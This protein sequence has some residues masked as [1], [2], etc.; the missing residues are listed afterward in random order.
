MKKFLLNSLWIILAIISFGA[1]II[2]SFFTT[3]HDIVGYI[4]M[5]AAALIILYAFLIKKKF[6][7]ILITLTALICVG[8]V[9]FGVAEAPIIAGSKTDENP[10]AAY[11]IV[12]GAGVN[13]YNPSVTLNNRLTA[14]L[15]YLKSYPESKAVV[16]GGQGPGE[17]VTEAKAM[18]DWLIQNGIS[19]DRIIQEDKSTSTIE[20]L[21]F[22]SEKIE[23]DGGNVSEGVAIVSS[24]YHLYRAKRLAESIGISAKG[25]AAHTTLPVMK[26]NYFIRE[27]LAAIYMWFFGLK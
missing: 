24:E 6:R 23:A 7:K 27:G 19:A 4:L 17:N 1:G 20:N 3:G 22:S 21:T 9:V 5:G 18:S 8:A 12:L 14:A 15:D 16:S 13:G 25:V 26:I 11:I 2:L 10:G